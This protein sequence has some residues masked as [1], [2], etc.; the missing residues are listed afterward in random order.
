MDGNGRWA[1]Q[2]QQ[3]RS[4]GHRQGLEAARQLVENAVAE[5]VQYLTLFAF[6]NEN[7]QRPQEEVG[8][9]LRLFADAIAREGAALRKN[10]IRLRFIGDVS[11]F[12]ASLRAGISGLETLTRGG[13]R[14]TLTLAM[15]YSGRWDIV[16]AA[17][18]LA[19]AGAPYTEENFSRYLSTAA[20]PAP[21]LLIRTGGEKRI[22]NF[23]LWQSAYTE[24]Y[25][26]R[27][28]WPDFNADDLHAAIA[29]F[30]QRERRYGRVMI[31][32]AKHAV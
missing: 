7:W 13:K 11:Q 22:S 6:S 24:L 20:L 28:L 9:L 18:Q 14:L 32:P 29:D 27:T 19:A 1:Q 2:R 25:F 21:D 26:T 31:P 23:M 17:Q 3:P 8:A 15:G 10:D 12:P 16:Q 30:R 4:A 5:E